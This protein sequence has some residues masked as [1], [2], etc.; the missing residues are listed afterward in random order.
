LGITWSPASIRSSKN[1]SGISGVR[2]LIFA[3]KHTQYVSN[4][5]I[6]Q[7]TGEYNFDFLTGI[8]QVLSY[9][10]RRHREIRGEY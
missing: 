4:G 7:P 3:S 10:Q 9:M 2:R 5:I 8:T 1:D 6:T